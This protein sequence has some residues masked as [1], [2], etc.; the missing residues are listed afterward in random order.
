MAKKGKADEGATGTIRHLSGEGSQATPPKPANT[1]TVASQKN[2]D[3]K[4]KQKAISLS[5]E[6]DQGSQ[7]ELAEPPPQLHTSQV[8]PAS[9]ELQQGSFRSKDLPAI[10]C[11]A[12]PSRSITRLDEKSSLLMEIFGPNPLRRALLGESED[13]SSTNN[14]SGDTVGNIVLAPN[15]KGPEERNETPECEEHSPDQQ[16]TDEDD[17]PRCGR[18]NWSMHPDGMEAKFSSYL[19]PR[20]GFYSEGTT[21]PLS[22]SLLSSLFTSLFSS[23][24]LLSVVIAVVIT[25]VVV[26]VVVVV[27]IIVIVDIVVVVVL[28]NVVI[29][30]GRGGGGGGGAAAAAGVIV[31]VVAVGG[32]GAA[33]AA[34]A[35]TAAAAAAAAAAGVR[36]DGSGVGGVGI[37]VVPGVVGSVGVVVVV[38]GGGGGVGGGDG[39][40][41]GVGVCVVV[42]VVAV[43][44]GVR[45]RVA[46]DWCQEDLRKGW[47]RG[48]VDFVK[49]TYG[50]DNYDRVCDE[51][52]HIALS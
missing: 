6:Q 34:A 16:D 37:A 27:D 2:K 19:D 31:V 40:G 42:G 28:I 5:V 20:R 13:V 24:L 23:L 22:F 14:A 50:T 15:Q 35:A 7:Q 3:R 52:E 45:V 43:A 18:R 21:T 30:G 10:S 11:T 36:V 48:A 8:Q 39:V 47:N 4:G 1:V 26:A 29:V 51:L 44:V 33:A 9:A 46:C 49:K 38:G 32:G 17:W 41:V 25:V 12:E